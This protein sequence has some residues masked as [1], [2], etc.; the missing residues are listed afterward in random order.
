[1]LKRKYG[2]TGEEV[3][4]IGFGGMRFPE[5]SNI[6]KCAELVRYAYEKGI[7]Y[8]D[9]A[10][11]YCEDKSQEIMGV[12]LSGLPRESYYISTKCAA[13]KAEDL[14]KSLEKSLELLKV[15]CIDFF[16]IWWVCSLESWQGRLDGGAVAEA[17][18]ARDE[19]LIKHVVVSSHLP[20]GELGKVL[21]DAPFEGA[22]LGYNAINFPYRQQALDIAHEKNLGVVTMNPLSGG[23]IPQQAERFSFLKQSDDDNVVDSALRFNLS[24]PGVTC[25]LVGFANKAEVDQAVAVAEDFTPYTQEQIKAIESNI[26]DSFEGLCTGCGYCLP[27]PAHIN[28]P[29]FMDA[30]N[31]RIL[32]DDKPDTIV[33]RLKWH[34]Q[35]QWQTAGTCINCG[36]C[37]TRCTQHLPIRERLQHIANLPVEPEQ[38]KEIPLSMANKK[39]SENSDK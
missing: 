34:W 29:K 21:L 8:F 23:I 13:P 16:H 12:A 39:E 14:R 37:E 5:P 1:M 3:T 38:K 32:Q 25:A 33:N 24:Q 18:K 4:A 35:E 2:K 22:T 30:Y 31:M 19:G 15:D 17:F 10:P 20:G 26:L 9:T 27:C 6:E 28:I 7:N 36:F 11:G